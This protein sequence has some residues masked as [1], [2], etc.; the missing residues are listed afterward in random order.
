MIVQ[1]LA[2]RLGLEVDEQVFD[3]VTAALTSVKAG[4]VGVGAVVGA[5]TFAIA[6]AVKGTIDQASAVDKASQQIGVGAEAFQEIEYAAARSS[7]ST[8]EFTGAMNFLSR[9]AFAASRGAEEQSEAFKRIGVNIRDA[10]GGLKSS[11][12]LL[13]ELSDKFSKLPDGTKK[14][15]MAMEIFGR[16]GAGLIKFLNHGSEGLTEM[17]ARARDLG[18]VLSGEDVKAGV[19]LGDS[20]DDL[21]SAFAGLRNTIAG[22]LIKD[23]TLVVKGMTNWVAANR[24]LLAQPLLKFAAAFKGA[25]KLITDHLTLIKFALLTAAV[26]WGI[27]ALAVGANVGELITLASWYA[28]VGIGAV[29]SAAKAS[30]AW[31]LAAAPF[32]ALAALIVLIADELYTFAT[33]GD[34]L[35]GRLIKYFDSFDPKDNPWIELFKALGSLIFDFSDP[36]KWDRIGEAF[37]TAFAPAIDWI[38]EKFTQLILWFETKAAELVGHLPGVGTLFAN[39]F[40]GGA[41]SPSASASISNS[42]ADN[43]KA[44]S[45][46]PQINAPISITVPPGSDASAIGDATSDALGSWT[47]QLQS[48]LIAVDQ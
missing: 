22:P 21:G 45:I 36:K 12:I 5:A 11:D 32:I 24:K 47:S 8:E 1:E 25:L 46:A 19:E 14:S 37:K 29:V 39:P 30:A 20:I 6:A 31:L 40:A 48:S 23:L 26:A 33:G 38:A 18:V 4:L 10:Q 41:T 42:S 35:L 17:R 9:T 13:A 2:A 3:R 28:A 7:V 34:S 16:S 43:S 44:T 27:H 15:G